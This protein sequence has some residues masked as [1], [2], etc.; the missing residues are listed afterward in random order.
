MMCM[1]C[2]REYVQQLST[3]HDT[4]EFCSARCEVARMS[5]VELENSRTASLAVA[6]R[7]AVP[8]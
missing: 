8:H 1:E 6:G 5:P 3:A 2:Y 7:N 4:H